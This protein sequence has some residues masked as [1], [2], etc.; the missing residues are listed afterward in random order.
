MITTPQRMPKRK[1][2]GNMDLTLVNATIS[3]TFRVRISMPLR[4]ILGVTCFH[5]AFVFP[6]IL[7]SYIPSLCPS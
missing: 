1:Y 6:D 2:D 3:E 7:V 4:E 5:D